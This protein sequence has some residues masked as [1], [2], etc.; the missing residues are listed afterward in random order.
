M[1]SNCIRDRSIIEG[2]KSTQRETRFSRL[3]FSPVASVGECS[4]PQQR[5]EK[6]HSRK[7]RFK[8][9]SRNAEEQE[10][11]ASNEARPLYC[12]LIAAFRHRPGADGF[13]NEAEE[14][15]VFLTRLIEKERAS[16]ASLAGRSASRNERESFLYARRAAR[17]QQNDNNDAAS[18]P[19]V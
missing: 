10:E 11:N 17:K 7:Q 15:N 6:R 19:R 2:N 16:A 1:P 13:V 3:I 4:S 12:R 8:R 9:V 18:S 14:K 5:E